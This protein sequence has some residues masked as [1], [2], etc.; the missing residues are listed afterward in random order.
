M[1]ANKLCRFGPINL[2]ATATTNI[3]NPKT[4]TGGTSPGGTACTD[5]YII[6]RHIRIVNISDFATAFSL[7]IGANSSN[8]AGTEFMGSAQ[9]IPP[10][11]YQDWFG[12]VRLDTSD[13][14]CGGAS[15][16]GNLTFEAEGE[17]GVA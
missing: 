14:L 17:V 16:N 3:L 12:A 15:I 2:T 11:S 7:F 4:L 10:R 9:S 6:L 13:Y 1:S 5:T 8:T